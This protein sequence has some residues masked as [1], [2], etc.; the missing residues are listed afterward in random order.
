MKA[1]NEGLENDFLFFEEVIFRFHV[2]YN[3]THIRSLSPFIDFLPQAAP[4]QLWELGT[5]FN[6]ARE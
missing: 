2:Q 3:P 1:Q 4:P 5:R 6:S